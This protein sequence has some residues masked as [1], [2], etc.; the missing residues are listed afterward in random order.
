MKRLI[1]WL[2]RPLLRLVVVGRQIAILEE[3][4]ATLYE[5]QIVSLV[6]GPDNYPRVAVMPTG[7]SIQ[8]VRRYEI[9]DIRWNSIAKR[10]ETEADH[11]VERR[12]GHE[13]GGNVESRDDHPGNFQANAEA[14]EHDQGPSQEPRPS[15]QANRGPHRESE[16]G[17]GP[18]HDADTS[19]EGQEER[20]D[21]PVANPGLDPSRHQGAMIRLGV[22]PDIPPGVLIGVSPD[23]HLH[24]T[25]VNTYS[26]GL[27]DG[28]II[29]GNPHTIAWIRGNVPNHEL[30]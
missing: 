22:N 19:S 3:T 9:R 10:F 6:I 21:D 2:I 24:I 13:P 26:G 27:P 30:H 28:S 17:V 5:G 14:S 1:L 12:P 20:A 23:Q 16:G 7:G 18:G 8:D 29:W 11:A 25:Q 4:G 15:G